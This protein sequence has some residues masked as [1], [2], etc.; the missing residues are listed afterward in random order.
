MRQIFSGPAHIAII[1][2]LTWIP[3]VQGDETPFQTIPEIPNLYRHTDTCNCYLL[4]EGDAALLLNLGAGGI[5][6]ESQSLGITNIEWLLL[7]DHHRE[8][9]QGISRHDLSRTKIASSPA[10]R[11][12]LEDP[13]SFRQWFPRLNDKY[14]VYGAS[15]VRPPAQPITIS[16]TLKDG[17]TL[18]WRGHTITC[19]S[20]PGTSPGG[21]SYLLD[22][23]GKTIA[24]TGSIIHEGPMMTNWFDTEWDYGF[25]KGIDTLIASVEKLIAA[26]IDLILPSQGPIIE[27]ALAQLQTNKQKL[28]H[29][30]G[31]Y[32]RGYP[33]FDKSIEKRDPIS[34]P[35]PIPHINRVTPHLYKLSHQHQ[36]RN[37]AIII[38]DKLKS[39]NRLSIHLPN[40]ERRIPNDDQ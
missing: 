13:T 39:T 34:K 6:K 8:N 40:D 9:L 30:R 27:N 11:E 22:I 20:T 37:F 12:I 5:L 33:V 18:S 17:E 7:T 36:G 28:E 14:S 1:V 32:V 35:T 2:I 38:S 21:M 26:D 4:R 23:D 29:F 31:Y 15:Y 3:F 24:C 16:K 10:E 19:L 25:G